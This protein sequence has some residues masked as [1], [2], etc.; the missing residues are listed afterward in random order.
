MRMFTATP[1]SRLTDRPHTFIREIEEA[2]FVTKDEFTQNVLDCEQTL[3]RIGIS[4]LK[5][6]KDCEDAVQETLLNAYGNLHKLRKEEY[7]KTW[8]IRILI[9]EC[10]KQLKRRGKLSAAEVTNEIDDTVAE[11]ESMPHSERTELRMA[12]EQLEPKYRAVIVMRYIEGFSVKEMKSILRI[13]EG[14]VKSRLAKAR[15]LLGTSLEE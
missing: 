3:Y 14:T 8:L 15:K 4:M 6:E 2:Y 9:N 7:F 5:N 1:F 11:T 10:N 12:V 13:P